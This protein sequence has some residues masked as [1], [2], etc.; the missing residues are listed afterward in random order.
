[1]QQVAIHTPQNVAV[2]F[3]IADLGKR[4]LAKIIDLIII[5]LVVYVMN[6]IYT[7]SVVYKI[8]FDDYLSQV[9]FQ[10]LFFLPIYTYSLWIEILLHGRSLGKLVMNLQIM[11]L[12]GRTF[13]WENALIRWM[14][15][16]IDAL[17]IGYLVA[18]ISIGSTKNGQRIGDL[19]A[20]TV[21]VSKK[22]NVGINQTILI[23]LKDDYQPTYSQVIRLSDNDMRIIKDTFESALNNG[24][25]AI[26][27]KLR[28]KIESVIDVK[29]VEMNDVNFVRLVMRDFNYFTNQ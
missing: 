26:I 5:I 13:S 12:D 28:S 6:I 11:R 20:G 14:C 3:A 29:N 21:V 8:K 18:L 27:K 10:Q 22:K 24:D 25:V 19:A 7:N 15:N 4:L 23:H 16:I 2:N 9:A 1:M 17:P